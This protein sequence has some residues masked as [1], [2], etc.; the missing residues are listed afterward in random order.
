MGNVAVIAAGYLVQKLNMKPV[1]ELPSSGHFDVDQ[2]TVHRGVI[3]TPRL[4]RSVFY[5]WSNPSGRDLVVFLGEAQPSSSGYA[6]AHELLD[7]AADLGIERV[8]TFASMAS[9]LHPAEKPRV[10]GAATNGDVL[11]DLKH[12]DVQPLEE[13]QIGGLNGVLLGAAAKRG[14]SGMCLL[15]EMPFF[16]AN[17]ANPKA[18]LAILEVFCPLA[19]VELDLAELRGASETMEHALVEL[20]ERLKIQEGAEPHAEEKPEEPETPRKPERPSLDFE[21]RSRIENLFEEARKD[22]SKAVGLKNELDRLGVFHQY[23]NRFL[24]LFRRAG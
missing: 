14:T 15:G 20:M 4:P 18:S 24:D 7:Q 5:R 10:F 13:G 8:I 16:A 17:V 2:V 3:G 21:T 9:Q 22:R 6:F 11:A 12:L 23:E 1:A 19:G